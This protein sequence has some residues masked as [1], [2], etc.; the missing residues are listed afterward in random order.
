MAGLLGDIV[1]MDHAILLMMLARAAGMPEPI[2]SAYMRF[3]E[4]LAIHNT[5]SGGIGIRYFKR[6]AIPQ[7]DP[8]SGSEFVISMELVVDML[9]ELLL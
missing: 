7:G 6:C 3:Q 8:L 9:S 4:S 2:L 5:I 1:G